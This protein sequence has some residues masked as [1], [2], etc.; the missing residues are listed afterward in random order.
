[1]R[2]GVISRHSFSQVVAALRLPLTDRGLALL[3]DRFTAPDVRA[4]ICY[5]LFFAFCA[6][7]LPRGWERPVCWAPPARATR[8]P[9]REHSVA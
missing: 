1:M 9:P 5:D 3:M 7:P 4:G 8:W 6:A 2:S